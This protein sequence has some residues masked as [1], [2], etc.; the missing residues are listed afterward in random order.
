MTFA[1]GS[2]VTESGVL[3]SPVGRA[4]AYSMLGVLA[5]VNWK[6]AGR[7]AAEDKVLS[8]HFGPEWDQWA[9]RVPYKLIPGIY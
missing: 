2:L 4:V 9:S 1:R 6:F 7:L 5:Y 3:K 8:R